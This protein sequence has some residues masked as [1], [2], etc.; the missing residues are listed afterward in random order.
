MCGAG[1]DV[2]R[3]SVDG[4]ERRLGSS[5]FFDLEPATA[6]VRP[7]AALRMRF[8]GSCEAEDAAKLASDS[9]ARRSRYAA[10]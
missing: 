2:I 7:K 1:H 6:G 4:L 3:S 9:S 8:I 10:A 5:T